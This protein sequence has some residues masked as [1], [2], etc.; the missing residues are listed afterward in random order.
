MLLISEEVEEARME[1]EE[2][3][4]PSGIRSSKLHLRDFTA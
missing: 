2:T 4:L 1:D 3:D